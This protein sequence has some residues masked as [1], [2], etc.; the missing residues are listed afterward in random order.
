MPT[1]DVT[2]DVQNVK[3][4]F[5][6]YCCKLPVSFANFQSIHYLKGVL[7]AN[8]ASPYQDVSVGAS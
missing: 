3:S 6:V 8:G 2:V 5:Y 7:L 1:L 4:E